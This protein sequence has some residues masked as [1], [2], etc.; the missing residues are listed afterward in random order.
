MKL[1]DLSIQRPVLASMVSLA[2]VLFGAIGW[3]DLRLGGGSRQGNPPP[4]GAGRPYPG[5]RR[6]KERHRLG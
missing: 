3:L 5:I 2:L 1:S 4:G 6:G